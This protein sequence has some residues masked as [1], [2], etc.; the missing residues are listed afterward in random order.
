MLFSISCVLLGLIA[1][2]HAIPVNSGI[3]SNPSPCRQTSPSHPSRAVK[4]KS[5]LDPR[6]THPHPQPHSEPLPTDEI[7]VG[8]VRSKCRGT[9]T[10]CEDA[11]IKKEITLIIKGTFEISIHGEWVGG[12]CEGDHTFCKVQYDK[13]FALSSTVDVDPRTHLADILAENQKGDKHV[14]FALPSYVKNY[15]NV[16]EPWYGSCWELD[17]VASRFVFNWHGMNSY[18]TL[19]DYG[20]L[21]E[22]QESG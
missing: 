21:H 19:V 20:K 11:R 17:T 13:P 22:L 2:I 16:G 1:V 18:D 15:Y 4:S 5:L 10:G 14:V 8:F 3:T 9:V 12:D 6:H 7:Y